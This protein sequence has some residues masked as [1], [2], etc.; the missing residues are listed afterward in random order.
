M[1]KS[2][3]RKRSIYIPE[4]MLKELLYESARLDRTVSW[5][6]QQ[7]VKRALPEIKQLPSINDVPAD[8]Q[9]RIDTASGVSSPAARDGERGR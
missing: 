7:C 5:I 9:V 2:D 3:K 4:D 6:I 8:F 1:S